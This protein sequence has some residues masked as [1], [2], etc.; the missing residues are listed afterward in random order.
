[1]DW[2]KNGTNALGGWLGEHLPESDLRSLLT[3]GIVQGVGNVVVFL[4][5]IL[6]LYFFLGILE[7]TGYMARAAFIMDRLMSP[8]GPARQVLHPDAEQFRLRHSRHHGHA[9]D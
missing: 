9:D 2:I 1:M 8:R 4:P 3:D 7:D 5:Q 6:I